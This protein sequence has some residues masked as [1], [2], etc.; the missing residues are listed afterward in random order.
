MVDF[1][2]TQRWGKVI[3]R[4]LKS[5]MAEKGLRYKDLSNRLAAMDTF[6]S[7]ANLRQKINRGQLSAQLFIQ[8]LLVM[9][10]VIVFQCGTAQCATA[11]E[12]R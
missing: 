1:I 6:Q 3:S 7:E 12:I 10:I 9:E 2:D 8:L 11:L 5:E 4:F